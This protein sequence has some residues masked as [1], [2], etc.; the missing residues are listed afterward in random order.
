MIPMKTEPEVETKSKFRGLQVASWKFR[1]I[2]HDCERLDL[3]VDNATRS[4]LNHIECL[5]EYYDSQRKFIGGD[6]GI[7][8]DSDEI[9]PLNGRVLMVDVSIPKDTELVVIRV[10]A[11]RTNIFLKYWYV[12]LIAFILFVLVV[13]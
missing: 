2:T 8:L 3:V 11:K 6:E 12:V 7:I 1:M 10:D 4:T 9:K 5:V 13:F